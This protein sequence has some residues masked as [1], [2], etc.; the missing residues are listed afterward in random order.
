MTQHKIQFQIA[1]GYGVP[2]PNTQFWVTLE[3]LKQN[4]Y[5]TIQFPTINFQTVATN[6]DDPYGPFPS[7][8]LFTSDGF[9]PKKLRPNTLVT[10]GMLVAS[11][12]GVSETFSFTQNPSSLPKPPVGYILTISTLGAITIQGSGAFMNLIPLGAQILL[13]TDISYIL[14]PKSILKN[15]YIIDATF[16]NT[17]QFT[18]PFSAD[19]AIRDSHVSDAF[20]N[21]VALT[22]TGNGNIADKTNGILN[23]FVA[24]GKVKK[25]GTLKMRDPI[26]LSNL[27]SGFLAWD[28]A[29]A[30]NRKDK[31]NIIV[32]YG[33]INEA[34]RLLPVPTSVE[35]F[36]Y[37]A[38]S[39]DG[40]KT[41]HV[42]GRTNIQPTGFIAPD[43][44]GGFGDNRGVA[45]DKFGNIWYLTTNHYDTF[46][47]NIN[48]PTFWI[49]IDGG[50]TFS[51]A[52]TAPAIP[53]ELLDIFIYDYVQYCFGGDGLGNYGINWTADYGNQITGDIYPAV[54][55]IPITGPNQFDANAATFAVLTSL[56]NTNTTADITASADGR[57]WHQGYPNIYAIFTPNTPLVT[58][59]K[60]PGAIDANYAGP[61][62]FG[63]DNN[64][65][66]TISQPV[67][68]YLP[69]SVQSIIYDETRQA[70]YALTTLFPESLSSNNMR[71]VFTISRNNGQ[72]WSNYINI[73]NSNE[74]NRGFQSMALDTV[75]GNLVFGW[76]DGRNDSNFTSLQ[77]FGAVI[78]AKTL[79]KLVNK[80]PLS[81]PI[82]TLPPATT[83]PA[84]NIKIEITENQKASIEKRLER[85]FRGHQLPR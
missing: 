84:T 69:E 36:T 46:G 45:S 25:D 63:S 58:T 68:G 64:I 8:S 10:Q 43:I 17:T 7:G 11:N 13:P 19:D 74:G 27:V 20:D 28:T 49:S 60:S 21:V 53:P 75:T 66:M 2:I 65:A 48:Q 78:T 34:E 31:K 4:E 18:N 73:A 59:F 40:G 61:W 71:L 14:R 23:V 57:V 37:R 12:N 1:D 70:L 54:G 42:N 80:I 51:V 81:E 6:P 52:Y 32:S 56:I 85:K 77:Y 5:V 72:T 83:P 22:W 41:W 3:I 26:Q 9:L 30:I 67:A 76:Y 62:Q 33:V 55:F 16:T 35:S 50:K 39:F 15:N 38:V 82:Y 79:D 44:A 47:I 29:V 24:I